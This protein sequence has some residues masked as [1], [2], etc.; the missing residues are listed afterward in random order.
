MSIAS[1][2][3]D[4]RNLFMKFLTL[5]ISCLF[6]IPFNEDIVN[7]EKP[8]EICL[9]TFVVDYFFG[10]LLHPSIFPIKDSRSA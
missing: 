7:I 4:S 3:K 10:V 9:M 1:F 6:S 8:D 2:L 5:Y